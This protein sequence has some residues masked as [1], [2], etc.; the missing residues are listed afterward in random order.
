MD[1]AAAAIIEI[2]QSRAHTTGDQ[3]RWEPL[4]GVMES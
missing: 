1:D 3:Q 4:T 2:R